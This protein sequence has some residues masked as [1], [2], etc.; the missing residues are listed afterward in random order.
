VHDFTPV[1]SMNQTGYTV[2]YRT[3]APLSIATP[4]ADEL[5]RKSC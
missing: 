3:P 1:N 4:K 2:A 5:T